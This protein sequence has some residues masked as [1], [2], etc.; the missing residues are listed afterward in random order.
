MPNK[1]TGGMIAFLYAEDERYSSFSRKLFRQDTAFLNVHQAYEL[2]KVK[3]MISFL[4]RRIGK[5]YDLSVVLFFLV[6]SGSF[7]LYLDVII[8][9]VGMEVSLPSDE[10]SLETSEV[11]L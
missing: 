7:I 10:G 3:V 6:H 11:I 2:S 1:K 8:F 4:P 9:L 5:A